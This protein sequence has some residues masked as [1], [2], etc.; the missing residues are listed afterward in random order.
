MITRFSKRFLAWL[1]MFAA[2]TV[3]AELTSCAAPSSE[4]NQPPRESLD[5]FQALKN[6]GCRL[7]FEWGDTGFEPPAG[8][9]GFQDDAQG[10]RNDSSRGVRQLFVIDASGCSCRLTP[11]L[12]KRLR[13]LPSLRA[14]VFDHNPCIKDDH[15][16]AIGPLPEIRSIFL[17]QCKAVTDEGIRSLGQC[18]R[19]LV[20]SIDGT[21]V[22]DVGIGRLCTNNAQLIALRISGTKASDVCFKSIAE[23]NDLE[24]LQAAACNV[25]NRG[26]EELS[27]HPRLVELNLSE[28]RI[29]DGSGEALSSIANLRLLHLG[30][31]NFGD[32]GVKQ[33]RALRR[34]KDLY[35]INAKLTDE[36]VPYLSEIPSL[37]RLYLDGC[38]VSP[39][40]L[41]R[42]AS[43][44]N[45]KLL[46]LP[47]GEGSLPE[48]ILDKY[49]R[50]GFEIRGSQ[51]SRSRRDRGL[52]R[53]R[54]R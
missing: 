13:K 53:S 6:A 2:F 51:V 24:Y 23:L 28:T 40:A 47:E 34:L 45:L 52:P 48:R 33:L 20:C 46:S 26:V 16:K 18:P 22:T 42:L 44:P 5:T 17:S 38:R 1:I 21:S 35:L 37:E 32:A 25:G 3:L 8:K 30:W 7:W 11:S 10:Q 12:A 39:Q 9:S 49:E 27:N 29:D 19:L 54:E 43:L 36:G 14:I 41:E 50:N 31:T 15:L 4:L